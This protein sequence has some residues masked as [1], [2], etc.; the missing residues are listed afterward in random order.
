VHYLDNKLF[1]T[2]YLAGRHLSARRLW[3]E[4]LLRYV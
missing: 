4:K 2:A 3:E 1:D